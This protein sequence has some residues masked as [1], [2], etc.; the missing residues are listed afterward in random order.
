MNMKKLLITTI[1]LFFH[2]GCEKI[3]PPYKTTLSDDDIG[4]TVLVE[5][6]TGHKC[7]KCPK[8]SRLLDDIKEFYP[9][10][11]IISVAIHP[12]TSG[13]T[14]LDEDY[15]YDFRTNSGDEIAT[16]VGV[17]SFIP[18]GTINRVSGGLN[19]SQVFIKD[20]WAQ[21]IDKLLYLNGDPIL[22][23][24]EINIENS[25][26]ETTRL[27]QTKTTI[28]ILNELSGD[29]K[30]CLFIMES[31]IISPQKDDEAE[32]G[33]TINY[34]H[35][36]IYRCAINGSFGEEVPNPLTKGLSINTEHVITL[37]EEN[38][39]NWLN[40]WDNI[41]NCDVVAYLYNTQSGQIEQVHKKSVINE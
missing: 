10:D 6:F 41:E 29:Y 33:H 20:N 28:N 15:S 17:T 39:I 32:N 38:N 13:L 4:K 26:D 36:N 8:A 37:T 16:Q 31:N 24:I 30:L 1:F 40:T 9:K 14:A 18:L 5:K 3:E 2:L 7:S 27:L 19:N 12:G 34:E 35:N 11:K 23:N 25:F 22:P 21:E